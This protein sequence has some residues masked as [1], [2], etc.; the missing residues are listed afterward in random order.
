ME[1]CRCASIDTTEH[2]GSVATFGLVRNECAALREVLIPDQIWSEYGACRSV[3]L[4]EASHRPIA[5]LAFAR[6]HLSRLTKPIHL[7]CL[8]NGARHL[9]LTSQYRKD[10]VERW[11]FKKDA[12]QRFR[13]AAKFQGRL[14][15]LQFVSW[16]HHEGWRIESLEAHGG[17]A[18]VVATCP[19]GKSFTF[20]VKYLGK[21]EILFDLD[22]KALSGS[23]HSGD[24]ISVYSPIDYMLFRVF[25]AARQLAFS[26]SPIVVVLILAEYDTY[27]VIPISEHWIDWRN[28][29]FFRKEVDIEDF[30]IKKY[31]SN[32]DLDHEMKH[33]ISRIDQI[34]FYD[35][36]HRLGMRRRQIDEVRG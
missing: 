1:S 20:E 5:Y 31:A 35:I 12:K 32:P 3:K 15:E 33:H 27:F 4:D 9:S 34:W 23:G 6:R 36:S 24:W 26:G 14:W 22:V 13:A 18:D 21:D 25:E 8:D 19:A 2:Y 30:L 7:F 10:L 28:P 16:L 17:P 29:K 11:M